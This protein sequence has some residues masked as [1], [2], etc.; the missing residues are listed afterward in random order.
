MLQ[1]LSV[2]FV[3]SIPGRG[4]LSVRLGPARRCCK[5]IPPPLSHPTV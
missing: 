5:P 3:L 4:Y 1:Y 2:R